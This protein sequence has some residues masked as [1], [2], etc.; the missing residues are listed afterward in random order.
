M[1]FLSLRPGILGFFIT[2]ATV[3]VSLLISS[4]GN[5]ALPKVETVSFQPPPADSL[6]TSED[7]VPPPLVFDHQYNNAANFISGIAA[8]GGS[9]E[10]KII[11]SP[12]WKLYARRANDKWKRF[13]T[14][15][16]LPLQTWGAEELK[17]MNSETKTL[18]YPFS[19]PDILNANIFFPGANQYVMVGLEPVGD[20]PF[21]GHDSID[22]LSNYFRSVESSLFSV[23]RFSFFRTAAMK[24]D[25]KRNEV[26]GTIPLIMIFLTRTG[27]EIISIKKIRVDTAGMLNEKRGNV[28]GVEFVFRKD[29]LHFPQKLYY[30]STD[31]SNEGLLHT[32]KEFSRY[33]TKLGK[34]STYLK[35]ASY[36]MHNDFF[37]TIR[38]HILVQSSYIL[39]DD[40]GIPYFYFGKE[41]WNMQLYGKYKGTISL[42]AEEYQ[43]D[44]LLAFQA[45]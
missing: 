7:S 2:P 44:Y 20:V 19:G 26:N 43:E 4:C 29:S 1:K 30:F 21:I 23:L 11:D 6:I 37:S 32:R 16:T 22:T 33:I 42:F 3:L 13:D 34:V 31:L 27:N 36:L 5:E 15:R 14:T 9:V 39:Q 12:E 45:D 25:L 38:E 10:N 24:T 40:S 35:S 18:F 17:E 8:K 28:P 41:N